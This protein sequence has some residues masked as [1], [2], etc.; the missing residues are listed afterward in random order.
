MDD[1][2]GCTPAFGLKERLLKSTR[3]YASA[4]GAVQFGFAGPY[5][6]RRLNL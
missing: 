2:P 1:D 5:H 6:A 3:F 4:A